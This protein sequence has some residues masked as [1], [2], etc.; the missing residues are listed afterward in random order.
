MKSLVIYFSLF[1]LINL[2]AEVINIPEDYSTIQAGI[3]ASVEGDT[4]LVQPGVYFETINFEGKEIIVGS[5][6]ILDQDTTYITQTIID[7]QQSNCRLV[8]FTN[9]ETEQAKIIGFTIRNGYGIYGDDVEGIG[10]YILNSSP[11]VEH[12]IIENNS[13]WWYRNGCGIGIKN[14][15]AIIRNNE[16][17]GNNGGYYGG[18]IYVFQSENVIIENNIIHHNINESGN[19]VDYGAGICLE[20]SSDILIR[21]NLIYDNYSWEGNSLALR[22]SEADLVGNTFFTTSSGYFDYTNLY[23][24]YSSYAEIINCIFWSN[25]GYYGYEIYCEGDGEVD[26]IYSN[27]RYGYDGVDNIDRNPLFKDVN[28]YDFDLNLQSPCINSGDPS[29]PYDPDGTIADMGAYFFDLSNFGSITGNVT[30]EEGIGSME[31]VIVSADT[32]SVTPFPDGRYALNMLP[33]IYDVSASLGFQNET[34]FDNVQVVQSQVT[35]G[36]NFYI[37]NTNINITINVIQD[38]TGD[39]TS[40]QEAIDIAINGDT[41]LVHPGSYNENL[42]VEE[43]SINLVSMYSTTLDSAYIDQTILDG[44]NLRNVITYYNTENYNCTLSGFTIE[45]GSSYINGGGG[46]YCYYSSPEI[47]YCK[48]IENYGSPYGGGICCY[49]SD[50]IISKSEISSNEASR[51][52]G[53][54]SRWSSP[55]IRDCK[56][57]DNSA[58]FSTDASLS[59]LDSSPEVVNCQI[60]NDPTA[61]NGGAISIRSSGNYILANNIITNNTSSSHGA[62]IYIS[63]CSHSSG[64]IS[65]NLIANNH[66]NEYG[67]GLFIQNSSPTIINCTISNNSSDY[68]GGAIL[69]WSSNTHIFNT[70]FWNNSAP[71]G[72]Q[73][74][75]Y[76]DSAD[77]SFYYSD[78]EGGLDQF[79]FSDDNSIEDYDGDYEYNILEDPLFNNNEN[80]DFQ[81]TTD[82]P[83]IDF[84]TADTTGLNLPLWDLAGNHRIWDGDDDGTAIIDIGAYEYGSPPFVNSNESTI[85]AKKHQVLNYPNPFNPDT[86]IEYYISNNANVEISM[87]NVKGQKIK[88]LIKN[89]S[90]KGQYSIKWN[91]VDEYGRSVSSGIY[92]YRLNVNGKTKAVNKCLLLK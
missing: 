5:N 27:I 54:Y 35:T 60:H 7:G 83:C 34:F 12:N 38:G 43:K 78:I 91:G 28:G 64:L 58:L 85:P 10:V 88:T 89:Y 59:F 73:I 32:F 25:T 77:P 37:E 61:D 50:P 63:D 79:G 70:I 56:I 4:V 6:F 65:N 19:G 36:I 46:I 49:N 75:L 90:Q 11:V 1:L 72:E 33:G 52:A 48:I 71:T 15:S 31:S 26:V 81:L 29:L 20:E 8:S 14:S 30:L 53:I 84:G 44:E 21:K 18:G 9:G 42:F 41:I 62:G 82:S 3:V 45:N 24:G 13:C 16:I 86:T 39:F 67:G 74:Y 2:S 92:F 80:N 87:Y 69:F 40:I 57:Y 51:G 17:C 66:S 23:V 68:A 55:I 22:N 47:S 76:N